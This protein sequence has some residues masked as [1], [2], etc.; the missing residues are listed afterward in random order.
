[1][2]GTA[3][4]CVCVCLLSSPRHG[5]ASTRCS[6]CSPNATAQTMMLS[7][8]SVVMKASVSVHSRGLRTLRARPVTQS[9]VWS[10]AVRPVAAAWRDTHGGGDGAERGDPT[11][12]D[13]PAGPSIV[14]RAPDVSDGR[15]CGA[16]TPRCWMLKRNRC[17]AQENLS[18]QWCSAR[19]HPTV[20]SIDSS[21]LR[22]G[23]VMVPTC[24]VT[25]LGSGGGARP[26]KVASHDAV[27]R[28]TRSRRTHGAVEA[29]NV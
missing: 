10:T 2:V 23:G 6:N 5:C 14:P 9:R 18:G 29:A 12:E 15:W 20:H 26:G 27:R 1:M 16:A 8:R 11:Y 25:Q 24:R 7:A 19:Q 28:R 17:H 4:L 3:A 22:V 21:C 13:E